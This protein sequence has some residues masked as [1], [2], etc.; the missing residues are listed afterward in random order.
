M[1]YQKV[2]ISLLEVMEIWQKVDISKKLCVG[3]RQIHFRSEGG[4]LSPFCKNINALLTSP[5]IAH[6]SHC[7]NW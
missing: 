4:I 7:E 5:N 3:E 6:L 2:S 1:N